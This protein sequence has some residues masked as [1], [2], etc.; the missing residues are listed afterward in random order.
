MADLNFDP[1]IGEEVCVLGRMEFFKIINVQPSCRIAPPNLQNIAAGALGL[2]TVDLQI[3]GN[4]TIL[5]GVPWALLQYNDETRPVRRT[6]EWLKTNPDGRRYPD[7][8]VDYEVETGND[9]A[10]NPSIFVRF[11]VDPDYFY[12]NGQASQEK[13]AQLNE[14]TDEVQQ[15]LLS[16][17]L[18]RWTYVRAGEARRELDVAS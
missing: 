9:H 10:G 14:F 2:G 17:G 7:Y 3:L 8:I 12:E 13:I 18:N 15:T 16:L 4:N 1:I 6:I 5:E 11:L